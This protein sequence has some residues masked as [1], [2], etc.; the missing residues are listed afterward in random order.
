MCI[1]NNYCSLG[2]QRPHIY[3]LTEVFLSCLEVPLSTVKR[4]VE[5][6]LGKT[7]GSGRASESA[8]QAHQL[9][10]AS[11]TPKNSVKLSKAFQSQPDGASS[12]SKTVFNIF[13]WLRIIFVLWNSHF[14]FWCSHILEYEQKPDFL[15]RRQ[16][17]LHSQPRKVKVVTSLC[18]L[19]RCLH[20]CGDASW[21]HSQHSNEGSEAQFFNSFLNS[22]FANYSYN[23]FRQVRVYLIFRGRT[24]Q[25]VEL[26]VSF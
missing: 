5:A 11:D 13:W 8:C 22:L 20:Q 24:L 26:N 14:Y 19:P 21:R 4:I 15:F 17:T 16:M 25:L 6:K 12:V 7:K 3:H 2:S 10:F 9:L 18:F 23:A 1:T